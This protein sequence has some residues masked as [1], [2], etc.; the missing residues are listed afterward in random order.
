LF[1]RD[2]VWNAQ[3]SDG[4]GGCNGW[5][6]AACVGLGGAPPGGEYVCPACVA[7]RAARRGKRRHVFRPE[8]FT[9]ERQ[10]EALASSAE[11]SELEGG[12]EEV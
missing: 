1:T 5:V 6:H 3:C 10:L 8:D 7:R 9:R 4:T 2:G 11:A 12:A